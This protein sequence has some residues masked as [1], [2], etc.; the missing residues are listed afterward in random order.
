M[1]T[2]HFY[3]N[4]CLDYHNLFRYYSCNNPIS[5]SYYILNHYVGCVAFYSFNIKKWIIQTFISS[6][7]VYKPTKNKTETATILYFLSVLFGSLFSYR[8]IKSYRTLRLNYRRLLI[9]SFIILLFFSLE[10]LNRG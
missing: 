2:L 7:K 8:I 6:L 10:R 1:A 4:Y 5:S 9:K 3:W